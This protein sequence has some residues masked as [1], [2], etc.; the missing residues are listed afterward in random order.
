MSRIDGPS[1]LVYWGD[2][3]GLQMIENNSDLFFAI[4]YS[5]TV[6]LR[7]FLDTSIT[8]T[9]VG[10]LT[11]RGMISVHDAYVINVVRVHCPS[12]IVNHFQFLDH[13]WPFP[14]NYHVWDRLPSHS[15]YPRQRILCPSCITNPVLEELWAGQDLCGILPYLLQFLTS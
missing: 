5:V 2:L 7:P 14:Y 8:R 1:V 11:D 6:H 12:S 4:V 3:S 10:G 15:H 9:N 13:S